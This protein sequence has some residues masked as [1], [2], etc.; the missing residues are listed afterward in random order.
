MEILRSRFLSTHLSEPYPTEVGLEQRIEQI[1][2]HQN[3]LRSAKHLPLLKKKIM[4]GLHGYRGDLAVLN[5]SL[6]YQDHADYQRFGFRGLMAQTIGKVTFLSKWDDEN[7]LSYAYYFNDQDQLIRTAPFAEFVIDSVALSSIPIF[8][9]MD[10]SEAKF[11]Q[12][13]DISSLTK[14]VRK[15]GYQT[16][17]MHLYFLKPGNI[18]I[19]N[20]SHCLRF[21][22]SKDILL[23]WTHEQK[24]T[25]G[26]LDYDPDLKLAIEIVLK[27]EAWSELARHLIR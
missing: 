10:R 5:T 17:V 21:D 23:E 16:G 22:V 1:L 14:S 19:K 27:Q 4:N 26:V 18:G 9:N 8:R 15:W 2:L 25:A 11:W 7:H 6:N 24:A 13:G 3:L 12:S 20:C